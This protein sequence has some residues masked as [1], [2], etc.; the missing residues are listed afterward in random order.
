MIYMKIHWNPM[1]SIMLDQL[2]IWTIHQP[3]EVADGLAVYIVNHSMEDKSHVEPSI[4]F[5]VP[6]PDVPSG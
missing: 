4:I 3:K 5:T 1:F 2:C 6:L